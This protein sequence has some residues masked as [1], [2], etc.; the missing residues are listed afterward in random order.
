MAQHDPHEYVK[1]RLDNWGRWC[2]QQASGGLGYPSMCAFARL[3][4]RSGSYEAAVPIISL[5]ASEIEQAVNS[6]KGKQSHLY[7]V[8]TLTYAQSL[9]RY[10]VAKR[11]ARTDRTV[12][13]N[14]EDAYF[15][16]DRWLQD[17]QA[18]KEK[19]RA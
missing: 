18:A 15:A 3:G 8:L 17:K 5:D 6:L 11:M 4:G 10:Q 2:Q 7:L 13:Q 19:Q 12:R 1:R 9:P 14:L 16:I